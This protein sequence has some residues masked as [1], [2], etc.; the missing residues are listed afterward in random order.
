MRVLRFFFLGK[1]GVTG[2]IRWEF[3]L[4]IL[5]ALM[6]AKAVAG[7]LETIGRLLAVKGQ[8]IPGYIAAAGPFSDIAFW[9]IAFL[10]LYLLVAVIP[11]RITRVQA[12]NQ[13]PQE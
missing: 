3:Q 7:V 8:H 12:E 9:P 5:I 6:F 4:W 13:A 2:L 10:F 11:V 1:P